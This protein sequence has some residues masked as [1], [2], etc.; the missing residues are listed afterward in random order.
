MSRISPAKALSLCVLLAAGIAIGRSSAPSPAAGVSPPASL[1]NG[2]T[3]GDGTR[4]LSDALF[5][6]GFLFTGGI[7]PRNPAAADV[8]LD[9]EID[10]SDGIYL[11]SFLFLGGPEPR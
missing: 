10:I 6:F 3:N 1:L 4:D 11:L 7:A 8:N 9:S 5:I 2:D